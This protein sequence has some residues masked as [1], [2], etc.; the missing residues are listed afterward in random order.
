MIAKPEPEIVE[1]IIGETVEGMIR[2]M[3]LEKMR[4]IVWDMLYEDLISQKWSDLVM[5]AEEFAPESLEKLAVS[6]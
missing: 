2:E 4:Q 3:S 6:L 5:Q 1:E